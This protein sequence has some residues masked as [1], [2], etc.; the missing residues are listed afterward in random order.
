[1]KIGT[2]LQNKLLEAMAMKLPCITSSLANNALGAT[3]NENI[4]IGSNEKEYTQHII[5]LIDNNNFR[6]QIAEKGYQFVTKNYTWGGSTAILENLI[7]S[8]Q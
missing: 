1:M 8:T 6:E 7:T 5:N 2:G 3:P 4:L